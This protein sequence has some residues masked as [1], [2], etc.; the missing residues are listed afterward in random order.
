MPL[1]HNSKSMR[2]IRPRRKRDVASNYPLDAS[3]LI[4]DDDDDGYSFATGIG[5]V[6]TAAR[7]KAFFSPRARDD[8]NTSPITSRST[9][10]NTSPITLSH[11]SH[12]SPTKTKGFKATFTKACQLF[13]PNARYSPVKEEKKVQRVVK[14][15]APCPIAQAKEERMWRKIAEERQRQVNDGKKA[16]KKR[17]DFERV[18]RM[19]DL[20]RMQIYPLREPVEGSVFRLTEEALEAAPYLGHY[21]DGQALRQCRLS[22]IGIDI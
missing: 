17:K 10:S 7:V 11:L 8:G 4:M 3:F 12:Q 18:R 15:D 21:H 19:R 5:R 9:S 14:F 16:A 2:S 20:G 22:Q 13:K 6:S 1:I